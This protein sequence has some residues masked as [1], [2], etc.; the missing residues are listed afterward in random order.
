MQPVVPEVVGALFHVTSDA[1]VVLEDG[2]VVAWNPRA[3][4]VFGTSSASAVA[5]EPTPLD[6]VLDDLLAL[7]DGGAPT[8]VAITGHGTCE[9]IRHSVG[10]REVLLLRDITVPLRREEGLNRLARLSRELLASPATVAATTQSLVAE[11]KQLTGAAYSALLLLRECSDSESSHFSYDAPRHLFPARM[12]RVVGLLAVPLATRRSVRLDDIRGHPSG[13][14]LPGVHPPMGPLLVV[15]LIAG[16]QLLGELAVANPPDG[17]CFDDLDEALLSDLAAH[18]ALAV[19]WAQSAEQARE[20]EIVRQDVVD[21]ARHD[22]RTPLGAGQ[23]Y[24]L[25]LATR[26]DRLTP[27]QIATALEGVQSCFA[28]IEAFTARL[29][30]DERQA[31]VGVTPRWQDIDIAELLERVRRDAAVTTGREQAVVLR[32]GPDAPSTLAGDPD[33]VRQ[34]LDNL[35]GNAVQY[36]GDHG[37][38][39]ITLRREGD[40]VRLDV[41]DQGPGIPE[42]EQAALFER[43]S[44]TTS[45][46]RV[47]GLGLGLA[48]VQ[49]LVLAHGGLLGV[50]SRP[51]EGATFWVTFPAVVVP[52]PGAVPVGQ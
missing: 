21:A 40:H 25:L 49:R 5:G 42:V 45:A 33:L 47:P 50:S 20:R 17:R 11:A 30:V 8:R 35:V 14:G 24:A 10:H 38:V 19:R 34:V 46:S 31:R 1:V 26:R 29:L 16:D 41:R 3:E 37:P 27:E 32:S 22:I 48:I 36:A 4:Q 23:G 6:P 51:G 12:P 7:P 2:R 15:P 9:V 18:A 28:R 52:A 39:T 44:R 13:V 43:W